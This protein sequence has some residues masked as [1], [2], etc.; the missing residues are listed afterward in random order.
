MPSSGEAGKLELD[1]VAG[2]TENKA[3]SAQLEL[4][5]GLSMAIFFP[6]VELKGRTIATFCTKQKHFHLLDQVEILSHS[7]PRRRIVTFCTKEEYCHILFHVELLS[8][9]VPRRNIVTFCTKE[10][11]FHILCQVELLLNSVES[12]CWSVIANYLS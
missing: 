5:L 12:W 7:L 6:I 4:E 8:H 1:R 9:S 2:S 10:K 11:Y 3:Y